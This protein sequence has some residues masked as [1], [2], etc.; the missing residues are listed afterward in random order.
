MSEEL[1]G[2]IDRKMRIG[3][4]DGFLL[5][6]TSLFGFLYSLIQYFF[7]TKEDIVYFIPLLIPGLILPIYFGYYRGA[8]K[9]RAEDR[10]RGW[11]YL[12]VGSP[13]YAL[14][15]LSLLIQKQI[16]HFSIG[17]AGIVHFMLTISMAPLLYGFLD[18]ALIKQKLEGF[19]FYL[20]GR[21]S[22]FVTDKM[23]SETLFSAISLS[24]AL[25]MVP[26]IKFSLSTEFLTNFLFMIPFIIM[27][28]F[29]IIA[30]FLCRSSERLDI[31]SSYLEYLEIRQSEPLPGYHLLKKMERIIFKILLFSIFIA[32]LILTLSSDLSLIIGTALITATSLIYLFLAIM[33]ERYS[34]RP[35]PRIKNDV[36]VPSEVKK[37]LEKLIEKHSKVKRKL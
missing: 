31:L 36:E 16:G 23:S 1:K 9:D 29:L 19:I 4:I 37:V 15:L 25:P 18:I 10:V 24:L 8:L 13:F 35:I 6:L 7:T 22:S 11:L 3:K 28:P 33:S 21:K 26:L 14:P 34:P 27:I 32:A 30:Y 5:Y 17:I 20:C 12:I 2:Y